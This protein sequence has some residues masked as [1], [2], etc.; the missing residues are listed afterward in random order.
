MEHPLNRA[1]EQHGMI[2]IGNLAIEPEVDAGDGRVFEMESLF[3]QRGALGRVGQD[4]IQGVE[5]KCQDQEVEDFVGPLPAF[6][7]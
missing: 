7:G 5:G 3:A 6:S 1:V 2:E 4:A